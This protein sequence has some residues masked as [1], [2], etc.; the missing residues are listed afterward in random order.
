MGRTA[1]LGRAY[2]WATRTAAGRRR[3]AGAGGGAAR[4]LIAVVMCTEERGGEEE[5]SPA[6]TVASG[7]GGWLETMGW[8]DAEL[9]LHGDNGRGRW[10]RA[11]P[12][13]EARRERL[14]S[15]VSPRVSDDTVTMRHWGPLSTVGRGDDVAAEAGRA[16]RWRDR[17]G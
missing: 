15:L 16:K 6:G 12:V 1:G 13:N 4:V 8:G 9:S 5:A 11:F 7:R 14:P 17:E 2:R 10:C 3:Q